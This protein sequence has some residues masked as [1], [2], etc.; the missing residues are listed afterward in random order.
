MDDDNGIVVELI[1]IDVMNTNPSI[2]TLLNYSTDEN[3]IVNLTGKAS[4]PGSDDLTFTWDW[5]D[6]TTNTVTTYYNDGVS[7][8]PYPSPEI[9]PIT[10]TDVVSH[11][12]GDNGVFTVTLTVEDDDS[13]AASKTT[14]VTV[15]NIAPTIEPLML[16][17]TDENQGVTLQATASDK[18]S[19]DLIFTWDWGDGTSTTTTYYNNGVSPDPY[20]SPDVNPITVTDSATHTWGD[21]GVYTVTL[22][23][24]DDDSGITVTTTNVT[25]NNVPPTIEDYNYTIYN[26]EPRTHGYWKHQCNIDEP[27]GDHVGIQQEFIDAIAARSQVFTGLATKD[28]VEAYLT[29]E[30]DD[31]REKAKLQLMAL[32]LNV[33]SGKLPPECEIDLPHL[34]TATTVQEAIDEIEHIILMSNDKDELERVKDIADELNNHHGLPAAFIIATAT[35]SDPGSDDL[36]FSWSFGSGNYQ[37]TTHFN[38]GISPDP[39]PSPE[40]NPMTATDTAYCS[41][42]STG[43]FTVTLTVTDDDGDTTSVTF[44][45]IV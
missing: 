11:V 5:G 26:V 21:N 28:E 42:W 36:S 22:T 4:D 44:N 10:A 27:K 17:T 2:D 6:G 14:T 39:Y 15:R 43:T 24:E 8:D 37:N 30:G 7:P 1:T 9:N 31:M 41:Y 23:V 33:V 40:I 19:D 32:W 34:T 12:Y 25:V 3:V 35:A 38:N 16:Y 13:G 18:G 20:P 45:V 29:Y